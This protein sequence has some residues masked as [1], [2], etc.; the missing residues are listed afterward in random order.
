MDRGQR[1][2]VTKRNRAYKF[3]GLADRNRAFV[4]ARDRNDRYIQ[5][6]F[7]FR[8]TKLMRF[9]HNHEGFTCKLSY[10]ALLKHV[11]RPIDRFVDRYYRFRPAIWPL[12]PLLPLPHSS[13][14]PRGRQKRC[15]PPL[16]GQGN[17][18]TDDRNG[19]YRPGSCFLFAR[20]PL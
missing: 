15:L 9:S 18:V 3:H 11:R 6:K 4:P 20:D 7:A 2:T 10:P 16:A 14:L 12:L 17:D 1:E 13:R 5:R 19:A 8:D